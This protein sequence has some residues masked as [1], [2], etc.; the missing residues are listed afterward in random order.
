MAAAVGRVGEYLGP[1]LV[2]TMV[3]ADMK[4]GYLWNFLCRHCDRCTSGIIPR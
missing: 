2:G 3:A 4:L 1:L